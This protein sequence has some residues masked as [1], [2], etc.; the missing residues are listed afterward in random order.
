MKKQ[1]NHMKK[2][3]ILLCSLAMLAMAACSNS[4]ENKTE[5]VETPAPPP[6]PPEKTT[7]IVEPSS[8]KEGTTIKMNDQ[9]V[10]IENKDGSKKNNVKISGD[11]TNIE[12]TRPK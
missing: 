9:G 11:S 8:Q 1:N 12:I 2:N 7:V 3:V 6:A 10:S 5:P 4:S